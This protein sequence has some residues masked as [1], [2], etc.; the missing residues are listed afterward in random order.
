MRTAILA[1]GLVWALASGQVW[2]GEVPGD[3][4]LPGR[5]ET[6]DQET[7]EDTG[8][9]KGVLQ[10]VVSDKGNG[11]T[12]P[13]AAVQIEGTAQ[14]VVTGMD[15]SYTMNLDPGTYKIKVSFTSYKDYVA[16]VRI[17]PGQSTH[18]DVALESFATELEEVKVTAKRLRHTDA[19]VVSTMKQA[20]VVAT[21]ASSQLISR[22]QSKDAAEVV[23]K[24]PG[25]SVEE[26]GMVNV[27]GLNVRY[28]TVLLNGITAP[29]TEND[30]RA[31]ALDVIAG[32]AIDHLMLYKT[33][34]AEFPADFSGGL[35]SI[36]TK[37]MPSEDGLS[38]S[39]SIGV[40]TQSIGK[41]FVHY[42]GN[43]AD[44][45]GFGGAS[46]QLPS[47]FPGDI[48]QASNAE[49]AAYARMLD[50]D[51]STGTRTSLPSQ[52]FSMQW[53]KTALLGK[54]K[55]IKLGSLFALNYGYENEVRD[56]FENSRFGV[57]DLLNEQ[58]TYLNSYTDEDY[59]TKVKLNAI[60]NIGLQ[61][62]DGSRFEFKNIFSQNAKDKTAL[63]EGIDYNNDY[64][65]R[66]QEYVYTQRSLYV[67]QLLFTHEPAKGHKLDY[68]LSYGFT[69]RQEPDR[70]LVTF[71]QQTDPSMP[72]YEE[73]RATD[74]N[75]FYQDMNEHLVSGGL[76]YKGL[77]VD[78]NLKL[79]LM[80]GFAAQYK[81]RAFDGRKFI[82]TSGF[83]STLPSDFLF[84]DLNE[85][86]QPENLRADG[87]FIDENT[88]RSDA[89]TATSFI[90]AVYLAVK[91]Q[92]GGWQMNVGA[93]AEYERTIL[94][95]YTSDG[96]MPVRVNRNELNVFPS[97]N[98]SYHINEQHVIRAAYA[99]TINR[100]EL[101]EI[102]PYVYY[103]FDQFADY[104][105]NTDLR[106]AK[107]Q[108]VD[109]RYEFYPDAKD[110]I[111]VGGFYKH[112]RDPIE[113]SYIRSSGGGA[114]YTF[115]NADYA[116]SA[117]VE[118]EVRK[119][120]DFM[121]LKNFSLVVNAAWIQSQVRFRDEDFDRDRAMQGQSPYIV[122]AGLYYENKGWVLS[123]MYNRFGR[124]ILAV[125]EVFQNPDE[126]I[127]DIYE[128]P[129]NDLSF[130]LKKS[131]GKHW[132]IKFLASNLLNQDYV[133]CQF[134]HYSDADGAG[135]TVRQ[136]PRSY[137]LGMEF[138][139]GVTFKM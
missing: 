99:Y 91:L 58:P 13:F 30:S 133:E 17:V 77:L 79:E 139:I 16:E 36:V 88:R 5:L 8:K 71:R 100:P 69:N 40:N 55:D 60:G 63:R 89:Y 57:F 14:G 112:F 130:G 118:L 86:F 119:S 32:N 75:R 18:L 101:R 109:L 38:F 72:H 115:K 7:G 128:M 76:D 45:V 19:A 15:G 104:T 83:P 29:G 78:K 1:L 124:R 4:R 97:F 121:K 47:A 25:V 80:S 49:K 106:N 81:N 82:Y 131:I 10:G 94:D 28:N 21:G 2:S 52:S 110:V 123:L 27:R 59:A 127:P 66:E 90:P 85:I 87:Y 50:N 35:V 41:D 125:G 136:I 31:F 48:S 53:D 24:L 103:D 44:A 51:W 23:S 105:G 65:I 116:Y 84:Q 26:G 73:Y 33:A 6:N 134:A 70:R 9:E 114:I 62:K 129:R 12:L 11:E 92:L 95:G 138:Q 39:Y 34:S 54:D 135:H 56:R 113:V 46:R 61:F 96:S 122:N 111:A 108:N 22:S 132:E 43:G 117:G 3:V 107:I 102:A 120:L 20:D 126:D 98:T 74:V 42:H 68:R 67:G 93:R 64:H 37:S 137:K